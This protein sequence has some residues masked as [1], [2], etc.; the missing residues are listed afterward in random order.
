MQVRI[1]GNHESGNLDFQ[2]FALSS[3]VEAL[4]GNFAIETE[5]IFVIFFSLF[6]AG[7]LSIGNHK[8]LLIGIFSSPQYIHGQFQ[9]GHCIGMVGAHL[10][11][12]QV[13]YFNWPGI[14]AEYHNVQGIFGVFCFDE[15]TERHGHFF[16]RGYS[17]FP[18]ENHGM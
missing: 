1:A 12:G 17:V 5:S 9:S 7:W 8:N 18:I 11:V 10:K 6:Q 3:Q 13:F 16:G 4:T 14:I 15:F 2:L